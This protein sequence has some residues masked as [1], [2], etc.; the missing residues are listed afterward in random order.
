[1]K[2]GNQKLLQGENFA[3]IFVGMAARKNEISLE[4]FEKVDIR[5]GTV[6]SARLN[7][8]AKKPAYIIEADFGPDLGV[9][10]SSAQITVLY[11]T[12]ELVGK[13]IAAVVNFPEKQIA[14]TISQF[15]VLG[16]VG[17]DGKVVLLQPERP[18]DNGENVS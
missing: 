14:K 2:Q 11:Q 10:K 4:D 6:V 15:L 17:K 12:N 7:E 5:I 16:A 9:L 8:E 13:Q 1:M 3:L 18:V